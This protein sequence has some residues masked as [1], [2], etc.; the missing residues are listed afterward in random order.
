MFGIGL[1]ELIVILVVALLVV[2][3]QKL[4]ELARSIGRGLAEFRRASHDLRQ[5]LFDADE[6]RHIAPPARGPAKGSPEGSADSTSQAE[7]KAP[8]AAPAGEE[9]A[10]EGAAQTQADALETPQSQD[11]TDAPRRS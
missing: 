10:G 7:R 11:G 6:P 3:P 5:G 1:P 8:P 4:P 9:P 2:G